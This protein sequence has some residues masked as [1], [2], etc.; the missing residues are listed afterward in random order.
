MCVEVVVEESRFEISGD[1]DHQ[2]QEL[3]ASV[4]T[5]KNTI[6][7][8]EE[9]VS[10]VQRREKALARENSSL[11]LFHC[12]YIPGSVQSWTNKRSLKA[13]VCLSK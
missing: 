7:R 10:E 3:E 6:Q 9:E 2:V 8:L 12:W 13:H 1:V 4:R 5:L 11:G